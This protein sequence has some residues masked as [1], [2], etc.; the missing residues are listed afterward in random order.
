MAIPE[1][2]R[3][4]EVQRSPVLKKKRSFCGQLAVSAT[5]VGAALARVVREDS[6]TEMMIE[7]HPSR[8]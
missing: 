3:G 7:K 4:W 5:G 8:S 2:R 1:C 6:G